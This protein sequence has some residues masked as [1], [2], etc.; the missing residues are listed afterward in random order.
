MEFQKLKIPDKLVEDI[1]WLLV[2]YPSEHTVRWVEEL[3]ARIVIKN[4]YTFHEKIWVK[5]F[6]GV[7]QVWFHKVKYILNPPKWT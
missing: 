7:K 3:Y 4:K 1:N 5:D 6:K 2:S